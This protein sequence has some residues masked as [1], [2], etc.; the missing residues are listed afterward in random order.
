MRYQSQMSQLHIWHGLWFCWPTDQLWSVCV[1][2]VLHKLSA[3]EK[4]HKQTLHQQLLLTRG[5]LQLDLKINHCV[6]ID[7]WEMP[8]QVDPHAGGIQ[9]CVLPNPVPH[10]R[11]LQFHFCWG[12]YMDSFGNRQIET[13]MSM[14]AQIKEWH[15]SNMMKREHRISERSSITLTFKNILNKKVQPFKFPIDL[16]AVLLCLWV[17]I[18]VKGMRPFKMKV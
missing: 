12:I 2:Y 8:A 11:V 7:I 17:L 6:L 5:T 14:T 3:I 9:S 16:G 15:F 10:E 18:K 4:A 13:M 1:I